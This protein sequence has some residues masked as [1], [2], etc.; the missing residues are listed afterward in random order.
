MKVAIVFTTR[1]LY[2]KGGYF[3]PSEATVPLSL[4]EVNKADKMFQAQ[5]ETQ[6]AP[7][8]LD[9]L[10]GFNMYIIVGDPHLS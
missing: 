4:L 7:V 8:A 1:N 6:F 5:Q 2:I 9:A 3:F 10:L